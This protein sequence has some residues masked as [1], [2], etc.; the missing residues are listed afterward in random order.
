MCLI[1]GHCAADVVRF[2]ALVCTVSIVHLV[3]CPQIRGYLASRLEQQ[4]DGDQV[5]MR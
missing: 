2:L 3:P 4:E 5:R 1:S